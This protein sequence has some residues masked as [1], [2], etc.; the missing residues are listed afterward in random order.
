MKNHTISCK[1]KYENDYNNTRIVFDRDRINCNEMA[2]DAVVIIK[3]IK[4]PIK[5][6]NCNQLP[7]LYHTR[8]SHITQRINFV[9]YLFTD[10]LSFFFLANRRDTRRVL[11]RASVSS[12]EV[13][14]DRSRNQPRNERTTRVIGRTDWSGRA[15]RIAER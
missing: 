12:S 11:H 3:T 7:I 6:N 8:R 4:I 9:P 13:R 2:C 14:V 15:R 1:T 5:A 10:R